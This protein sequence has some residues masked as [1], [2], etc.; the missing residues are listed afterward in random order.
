MFTRLSL[1][2]RQRVIKRTVNIFHLECGSAIV[3]GAVFLLLLLLLFQLA[4]RQEE[5]ERER[6]RTAAA[7]A[8]H[9]RR[10]HPSHHHQHLHR[11]Q[12]HN[13]SPATSISPSATASLSLASSST[14]PSTPSS[15]LVPPGGEPAKQHRTAGLLRT[16]RESFIGRIQQRNVPGPGGSENPGSSTTTPP[17]VTSPLLVKAKEKCKLF[18][19]QR[20]QY[21]HCHSQSIE[22]DVYD[23]EGR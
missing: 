23:T 20:Q 15:P 3:E 22:M 17:T 7:A 12:H 5:E 9:C 4:R 8:H 19:M 2:L 6:E 16:A 11:H 18:S 10:D 14:T 1:Y 13:H 21:Q